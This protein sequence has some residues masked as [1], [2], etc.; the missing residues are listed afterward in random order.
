MYGYVF[1][2]KRHDIER[3]NIIY[4][5]DDKECHLDINDKIDISGPLFS[6]NIDFDYD[7]ITTIL[8][9]EEFEILKEGGDALL[10]NWSD[11][12]NRLLSEDNQK[13]TDEIKEDE[14]IFIMRE[15]NLTKNDVKE[16][17]DHYKYDYFDNEIIYDVYDS[18]KDAITNLVENHPWETND[19]IEKLYGFINW[20]KVDMSFLREDDE[21]Y[22]DL[23]DDVY[24]ENL[25]DSGVELD[26]KF[27]FEFL[28]DSINYDVIDMEDLFGDNY[29]RM[30]N[31][32][33][34]D[35]AI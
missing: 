7:D 34:V 11:I 35:F 16:I 10:D 14:I 29:Y 25:L 3:E 33:V 30:K 17:Y 19:V 26:D 5:K 8:T 32:K 12:R 1:L 9:E 21:D 18:T 4:I 23:D 6:N 28:S 2:C 15:Y 24:L 13:L 27:F 31:G 22:Q 20:D